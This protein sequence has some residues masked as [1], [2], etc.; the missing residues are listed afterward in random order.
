MVVKFNPQ[1]VK[2]A[3]GLSH[4][5]TKNQVGILVKKIFKLEE[6]PKPHHVTDALAIGI[7]GLIKPLYAIK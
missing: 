5:S 1:E 4:Q 7:A 2:G 3:A 6:M